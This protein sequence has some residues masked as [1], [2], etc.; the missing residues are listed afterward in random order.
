MIPKNTHYSQGN[1]CFNFKSAYRKM[2]LSFDLDVNEIY[3]DHTADNFTHHQ[4]ATLDVNIISRFLT[5]AS[6]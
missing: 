1:K 2:G 3:Y 4:Y 5:H 6:Y